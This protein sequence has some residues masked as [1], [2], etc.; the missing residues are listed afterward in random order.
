V[1]RSWPGTASLCASDGALQRARC[2]G[3]GKRQIT[4]DQDHGQV[5]AVAAL[6][7]LV[8]VDEDTAERE[9][10]PRRLALEHVESAGAEAAARALEEHDLDGTSRRR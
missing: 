10:E 6:E 2:D 1:S 4:V 8:A 7:L 5:D 9:S 3:S